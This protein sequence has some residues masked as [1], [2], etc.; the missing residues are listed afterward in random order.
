MH[1]RMPSD[2]CRSASIVQVIKTV[3]VF[4]KGAGGDPIREVTQYWDM[5]G[6]L[7]A[8]VDPNSWCHVTGT[9]AALYGGPD[10]AHRSGEAGG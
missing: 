5:D 4:G 6:T 10:G 9:C 7:L 1:D 3:A 8:T 2:A